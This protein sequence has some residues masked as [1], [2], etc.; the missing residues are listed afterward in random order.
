ML[1]RKILKPAYAFVRHAGNSMRF[2]ARQTW[3][4]TSASLKIKQWIS[5]FSFSF[6]RCCCKFGVSSLSRVRVVIQSLS[7]VQL[8]ATP[9]TVAHQA[10]LSFSIPQSLLKF[11]SIEPVM[12]SNHLILYCSFLLLPSVFPSIRVFFQWVGSSD[13]VAKCWRFSFSISPWNEYSGLISFRI[14]WFDLLL[15]KGLSGVR[16]VPSIPNFLWNLLY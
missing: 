6:C 7:D 11:M 8:F 3:V 1:Q 16:E 5:G 15:S 2:E 9:W 14:D 13:Q 12:P 4:H 10:S